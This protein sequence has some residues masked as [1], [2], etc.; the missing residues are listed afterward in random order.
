MSYKRLLNIAEVLEK[1]S[2]FLF[3]PR[4]TGKTTLLRTMFPSARYFD[5]LNAKTFR[6]LS[7]RPE[8]MRES[9]Q[10]NDK[11]VIID[12]VQKLPALLDEVH[13][14]IERNKK[15]RFVLTGSSARKLKRGGAN[16][17]AG[18][19]LTLHLHPLIFAE[20]NRNRT[21][22]R[23]QRGSLPAVIDSSIWED[24]LH[25]YVGTYLKEE[26][27]AEGLT[28]NIE[29]FARFLE[30]AALSN[31]KLLN[32]TEIGSDA[33]ITPRT[34]QN[35]YQILEDTLIGYQLPSYRK[36]KTRKAI[37]TAKFFFFDIGV[38]NT[39]VGRR[40]IA[41]KTTEYGEVLEQLLFLE[42]RAYLDYHRIRK[43]LSFWRSYSKQEVDFLIGDSIAIE[44]KSKE[45]VSERDYRGL[46]LLNEELR[47]K[48]KIV[49]ANEPWARKTDHGVEIM[50]V[51][52]FLREL[53]AGSVV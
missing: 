52:E 36:T 37:S 41:A 29:D 51:E 47:L 7:I 34:V 14:L 25:E 45:R 18:R 8:T 50:P 39:L 23:L 53:W 42:L 46:L 24:I 22:D 5:L 32:F 38:A 6:E 20:L 9:L 17:L 35:Y 13:L 31:G 27:Q 21:A 43:P 4:L 3:G 16:L 2:V 40:E 11:I 33:G 12:E 26:I 30:V 44:V 19:A 28:R 10:P 15:L 48:R 1:S 49:V